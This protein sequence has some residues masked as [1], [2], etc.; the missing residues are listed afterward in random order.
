MCPEFLLFYLKS[1]KKIYIYILY[2]GELCQDQRLSLWILVVFYS[3]QNVLT[4]IFSFAR[5]YVDIFPM[6][7]I[8]AQSIITYK[9]CSVILLR[10]NLFLVPIILNKNTGKND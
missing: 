10:Y 6:V 1:F 4:C 9:L 3:V 7:G 5:G 2:P 8:V